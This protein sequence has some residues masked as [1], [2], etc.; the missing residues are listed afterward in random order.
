MHHY[1]SGRFSPRRL[2]NLSILAILIYLVSI[3]IINKNSEKEVE[4]NNKSEQTPTITSLSSA[5]STA[6]HQQPQHHHK[7]HSTPTT[8][9]PVTD[10]P[11]QIIIVTEW[12]SGSS[13][14]G[15]LFNYNPAVFYLF[16]P[17]L[18]SPRHLPHEAIE[19]GI[20]SDPSLQVNDTNILSDFFNKCELPNQRKLIHLFQRQ[21]NHYIHNYLPL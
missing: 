13:F 6:K 8:K 1:F 11:T 12:R 18:T 7:H 14:F 19:C 2:L 20:R 15:D 21:Y 3:E 4:N 5:T 9:P 10:K 17:L 16:E